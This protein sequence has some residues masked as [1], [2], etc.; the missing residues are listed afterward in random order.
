MPDQPTRRE[1]PPPL[2]VAASLV[3]VQGIVL[4]AVAVFQLADLAP[5]R[6]ALDLSMAAFYAVYA[7][8]LIVAAVAL[9][10]LQSW[11]RGPV[12]ITQLIQLGLAWDLRDVPVAAIGLAVTAL[13]VIAGTI[14]PDSLEA[15]ERVDRD[16]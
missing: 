14:H 9:W 10:R 4:S 13:I 6:T 1:V 15:L 11:S 5:G 8:V 2:T 3:A 12:L 7:A 16:S